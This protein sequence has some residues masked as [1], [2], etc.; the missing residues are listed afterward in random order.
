MKR[1]DYLPEARRDLAD[2]FHY[3]AEHDP[4]AA[5]RMLDRIYEAAA[6]LGSYPKSGRERPEVGDGARSLV[7]GQYL[8]FHRVRPDSVEIARVVHGARDLTG[9]LDAIAPE[10]QNSND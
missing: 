4:A 5:D 1:I 2:I 10:D 6:R 8:I 7:V 9:L 3:I